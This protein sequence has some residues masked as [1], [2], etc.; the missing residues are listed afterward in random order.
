MIP[1][2]SDSLFH[3]LTRRISHSEPQIPTG[4]RFLDTICAFVQDTLPRDIA[5][6]MNNTSKIRIAAVNLLTR[7]YNV[8]DTE[9]TFTYGFS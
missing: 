9:S 7:I 5:V 3:L 1:V 8:I 2:I 6:D 4:K